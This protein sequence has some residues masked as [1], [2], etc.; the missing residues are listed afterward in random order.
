MAFREPNT[1]GSATP[2][3]RAVASGLSVARCRLLRMGVIDWGFLA[4][5]GGGHVEDFVAALLVAS[6]PGTRQVRPDQGDGGVDVIRETPEGLVVWQVKCFTSAPNSS[7]QG[8]ITK[9]WNRFSSEYV[10]AGVQIAEYH[11]VTP[12]TPTEKKIVWLREKVG[13][14]PFPVSWE[15]AAF[16]DGLA[17]EHQDILALYTRG[18]AAFDDLVMAKA[19]IAQTT[20]ASAEDMTM[21][22]AVAT[23][24]AALRDI[25]DQLD[26]DYL[27]NVSERTSNTPGQPPRP[28][29]DEVGL[30]YRYEYLGE[31]RWRVETI[32][33]K[34]VSAT[35]S[36]PITHSFKL[37]PK[38][39]TSEVE[40]VKEFRVWGVPFENIEGETETVGGPFAAPRHRA[41]MSFGAASLPRDFPGIVLRAD[42]ASGVPLGELTLSIIERTVGTVGG[43]IRLVARSRHGSCELEVRFGSQ[44]ADKTIRISFPP[45]PDAQPGAIVREMAWLDAMSPD[46]S[47]VLSIED[48]AT[49]GTM[50]DVKVPEAAVASLT[51]ARSLLA[52]QPHTT[53]TLLMPDIGK[54]SPHQVQELAALAAIYN[55]NAEFTT[56]ETGTLTISDPSFLQDG[57]LEGAGVLVKTEQPLIEVGSH[58]YL[59][60]RP[61]ATQWMTPRLAPG[62]V[63]GEVTAGA[64]IELRPGDDNRLVRAV[65]ADATADTWP[66]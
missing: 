53:S 39:G 56:W 20:P 5:R 31:D 1:E 34:H 17:A 21:R 63:P 42:D 37:L 8:Q 47:L 13:S 29:E 62:V 30:G 66:F 3:S 43:G 18:P 60:T 4:A 32:V 16:L 64:E 6:C 25:R 7:Q 40:A 58:E 24:E 38:P 48:I 49:V 50:T 36:A 45:T 22:D 61:M 27:I 12:W 35:T 33:P 51:V 19:V 9:S 55:G 57:R 28:G 2:V 26:P 65:V 59:I 46:V 10:E 52:L 14:V 23:R 44:V 54:A 41:L 15:G 11:L